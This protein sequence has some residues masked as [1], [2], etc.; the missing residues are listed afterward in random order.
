MNKS[1]HSIRVTRAA[2]A[3][4]VGIAVLVTAAHPATP[5]T[6]RPTVVEVK[7]S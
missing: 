5:G 3:A 1:R 7:L 2:C 6:K 4:V